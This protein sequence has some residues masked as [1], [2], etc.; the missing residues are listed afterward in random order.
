MICIIICI[1]LIKEGSESHTAIKWQNWDLDTGWSNSKIHLWWLISWVNMSGPQY[2][3]IWSNII[4]D[5]FM[6]VFLHE[7]YI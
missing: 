3:D 4:L 6:S 1:L 5:V 7:I 2:P